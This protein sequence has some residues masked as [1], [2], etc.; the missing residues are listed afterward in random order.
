M[1]GNIEGKKRRELKKMRWLDGITDST[2]MSL[3]KWGDSEGP[4]SL[5]CCS[6]WICRV[7]DDLMT[8][9]QLKTVYIRFLTRKKYRFIILFITI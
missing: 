9:Q 4:G 8:E 6:P 2:D 7:R 1:L 3:S 5:V